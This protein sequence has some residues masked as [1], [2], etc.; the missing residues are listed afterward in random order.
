MAIHPRLRLMKQSKLITLLALLAFG[1]S[2]AHAATFTWTGGNNGGNWYNV[3]NWDGN[4]VPGGAVTTLGTTS[5]ADLIIFDSE[6]VSNMPTGTITL[7]DQW[8]G[9]SRL[10]PQLHVRNGAINLNGARAGREWW[11]LGTGAGL[12]SLEIG[13]GNLATAA[14]VNG[15]FADWSRDRRGT[16][17][18]L[19]ILV[20]ADGTLLNDRNIGTWGE[21]SIPVQLTI[22]GGTVDFS[23]RIDG[24][25]TNQANSY[26][27]FNAYGSTF[28]ADLGGQLADETTVRNQF[29]DSFRL[30]GSLA[31]DLDAE[32]HFTNNGD[33]SFTVSVIP[34]PGSL[35]LLGL[36]GLMIGLRRR[37]Y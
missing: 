22:N 7:S 14:V 25:L 4:G 16:N 27:S 19:K 3:N 17:S 1:C 35:A 24:G 2:S 20:N 32:L 37:R 10:I 28:T 26:F 18:A 29:G 34:E 12:Y 5:G 9:T 36:G 23:G 11:F 33:G 6:T 30:G 21:S 15:Q 31:S 13:D 8:S